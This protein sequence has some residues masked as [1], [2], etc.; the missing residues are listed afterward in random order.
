MWGVPRRETAAAV[1]GKIGD[2]TLEGEGREPRTRVMG[3][4]EA[5]NRAIA[6]TYPNSVTAIAPLCLVARWPALR[7][8]WLS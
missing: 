7:A 5:A 1:V 6:G 4:G 8:E 2:G 3:V